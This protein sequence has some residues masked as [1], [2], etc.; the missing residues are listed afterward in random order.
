MLIINE[1][2]NSL[3]KLFENHIENESTLA[4]KDYSKH[5]FQYALA[6]IDKLLNGEDVRLGKTG[7]DG[8][9]SGG[10]LPKDVKKALTN[11][12]GDI[13][14]STV[15][16]FN[17]AVRKLNTRWTA[18]FKGDLTGY[19]QGLATKNKGNAF[20]AWF[21]EK[22]DNAEYDIEKSVKAIAKYKKRTGE[23]RADGGLNQK[24]PLTF[25][26]NTITCGPAG[27]YD[28]GKTVS[29]VTV[30]VDKCPP[31]G[32]KEVYLSLKYGNTVTFVNA[33][34]KKIFP[35]EFF[36]GEKLKGDG[37]TLLKMLCIDENMFRDVFSSYSDKQGKKTRASYERIDVTNKLKSNKTFKEFMQ[38]VMGY[39]YILVHQINGANIEYIDLLTEAAMNNFISD[40]ESATVEYPIGGSAKRVNV[41]VKYPSIEFSINI[42]SKDGGILPTHI[43]AD[44]KFVK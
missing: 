1:K 23:P 16:N 9:I 32:K 34:V 37:K 38:S 28:V 29:D 41:V 17:D 15:D 4:A 5:G 22:Y 13:E 11:L 39:G 30:P 40:I 20:E 27:N 43:M 25:S 42:R 24:R 12:K 31:T 14:N 10:S 3:N 8:V 6:I 36:D 26:G 44:Y 19:T 7:E 2:Y 18:I 21:I 33:G 35:K